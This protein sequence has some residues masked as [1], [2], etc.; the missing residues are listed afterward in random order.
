[1]PNIGP[2]D[3]HP[4]TPDKTVS[5]LNPA[6]KAFTPSKSSGNDPAKSGSVQ[7]S[8]PTNNES[9][10]SVN[11]TTIKEAEIITS[12]LCCLSKNSVKEE[13][14]INA[15]KLSV[16]RKIKYQGTVAISAEDEST[17]AAEPFQA[18]S[19]TPRSLP[20]L[21]RLTNTVRNSGVNPSQVQ[22]LSKGKNKEGA[23]EVTEFLSRE[24]ALTSMKE[25][26]EAAN[27]PGNFVRPDLGLQ[28]W[29]DSQEKAQP[30]QASNHESA[31]ATNDNLIDFDLEHSPKASG[32]TVPLPPGFIPIST[33]GTPTKTETAAPVAAPGHVT[34]RDPITRDDGATSSHEASRNITSE[35]EYNAALVAEYNEKLTLFLERYGKDL[36][37]SPD[38]KEEDEMDPPVA[39]ASSL[40]HAESLFP[41]P[42][43]PRKP[44]QVYVPT[45]PTGTHELGALLDAECARMVLKPRL[46]GNVEDGA[47]RSWRAVRKEDGRVVY[48]L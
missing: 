12:H 19:L 9:K 30:N 7:A 44:P 33:K 14:D 34:D 11:V 39:T 10:P 2:F 16:M 17:K 45:K 20:H 22:H 15:E 1:M 27:I 38:A 37:A 43:H 31:S 40:P 23:I 25:N 29:L 13:L 5:K 8:S 42:T 18:T 3:V 4:V 46:G 36:R 35:K 6:V 21:R 48:V 28:A 47:S 41:R 24:S 26:V 32:K